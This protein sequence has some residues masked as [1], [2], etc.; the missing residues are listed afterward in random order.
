[1]TS[2][3]CSSMC[4]LTYN[5]YLYTI[6]DVKANKLV[7]SCTNKIHK[8]GN[9][10]WTSEPVHHIWPKDVY[11]PVFDCSTKQNSTMINFSSL[12][13][14]L[15]FLHSSNRPFPSCLLP[16]CQNESKCKTISMTSAYRFISMQ[17]KCSFTWR[18][19]LKLRHKETF[20]HELAHRSLW[21]LYV[22][23]R[24]LVGNIQGK[25]QKN[26]SATFFLRNHLKLAKKDVKCKMFLLFLLLFCWWL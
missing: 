10:M 17:I 14:Q 7:G 22:L 12:F 15:P 8:I 11:F 24:C 25:F 13:I 20:I 26:C 16:L 6:K 2:S 21:L 3:P 5:L 4:F 19:V 1:M 23:K 18:L 9:H